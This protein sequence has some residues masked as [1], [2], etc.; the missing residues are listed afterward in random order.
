MLYLIHIAFVGMISIPTAASSLPGSPVPSAS[1]SPPG[2]SPVS[3][4]STSPPGTSPVS[5]ANL[6]PVLFAPVAVVLLVLLIITVGAF[7]FH[8]RRRYFN[9]KRPSKESPEKY[10]TKS[11]YEGWFTPFY[12]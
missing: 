11:V 6:W 5:S 8:K 4:A 3:S 1:T 12:N 2:T 10:K 7:V 9:L